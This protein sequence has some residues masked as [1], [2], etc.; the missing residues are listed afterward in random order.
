MK[1]KTS[2]FRII[3]IA[4]LTMCLYLNANSQTFPGMVNGTGTQSDPYQITQREHLTALAND[5]A[6]TYSG[7]AYYKLMNDIDYNGYT[8]TVIGTDFTNK[9]FLGHFNGN[10]K[11]ISN[12]TVT[13]TGNGGTAFIGCMGST[14]NNHSVTN[15]ALEN[16]NITGAQYTG[17]IVG[18]VSANT[19]ISNCYVTGTI[20]GATRTGG[21]VGDLPNG[22]TITNCYSTC[23]VTGTADLVGGI[24]G[25]AGGTIS[26]SYATGTITGNTD[27][28]GG[29]TGY[30]V[31]NGLVKNCVAANNSIIA[32]SATANI[33]RI[34][35]GTASNTTCQNN[36]ALSTMT[37]FKDGVP[38]TPTDGTPQSGV[39]KLQSE[40]QS[41][42]FYTTASNWNTA[43]WNFT[44][45][46]D[47]C[48]SYPYFLYQNLPPC[49]IPVTEIIN[50][51]TSAIT[52]TPTT[53][54][55]DVLPETATNQAI[56][57]SI[58][59][60][61]T[62]GATIS[63]NT[64]TATSTGTAQC[65]AT[66]NN[67]LA[68]GTPYTQNFNII[69]TAAFVPVTDI[70]NL[71]TT[72][73]V[74]IPLTLTGTVQPETATNKTIT[75]SLK[76]AGTTNATV[77]GNTFLAT[78]TGTATVTA[79]ILNG[80]APGTPFVKDFNITV[81]IV[82][83]TDITDVPKTA[84]VNQP[85]TLTGTVLP[86][87]ATYKTISWSVKTAG[88]T[89]ATI[90]GNTFLATSTGTATITAT[91]INGVA[92]GQNFVKDF[93]ITVTAT[94]VSVTDIK[95]V[96]TTATVSMPLTLTGTV[97]PATATNQTITWKVKTAGTTGATISGNVLNTKSKGTVTITATII[98]GIAN[99]Q[100]FNKDFTIKVEDGVAISEP[101]KGIKLTVY[102]NPTTDYVT[103][104]AGTEYHNG[105][106]LFDIRGTFVTAPMVTIDKEIR[107]YM[108]HLPVGV[109]IL[110]VNDISV[111]IIKK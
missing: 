68:P 83:V 26:Y 14:N 92:I 46:W 91:I 81:N 4:L 77:S 75:W 96:P 11:T 7:F 89:G 95:D 17:G 3:G 56:T 76:S 18:K 23:S 53:L 36:Y 8:F 85:L 6:N 63:G 108:G 12:I 19:T 9:R 65:K 79:T 87:T 50:L 15:L 67:G 105:V 71:S 43:A 61:G 30:L 93:D 22:S 84:I 28:I 51:V 35:G 49:F 78:S 24:T 41:E 20:S 54:T 102:P 110:K 1:R 109:Y 97:I 2:T 16:C 42:T 64:F 39:A 58:I 69:V 40:L 47:I 72:A 98:N 103:I 73:T 32:Q 37:L 86:S 62:T 10:G 29:I 70:T 106:H 59:N 57:W 52:N 25:H 60:P 99:G 111:K 21:L 5:L 107:V 80:L 88:T 44:E 101:N 74:N 104:E 100:N 90:S 55:G 31:T 27:M 38:F 66:I 45:I 82:S 48:Q 94:F 13:N 33:N 34:C